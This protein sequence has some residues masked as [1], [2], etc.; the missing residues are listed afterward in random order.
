MALDLTDRYRNEL[1]G[2][3]PI[4]IEQNALQHIPDLYHHIA[5]HST[6]GAPKLVEHFP[7]NV[8]AYSARSSI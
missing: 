8:F 4:L 5:L 7:R 3:S 6:R 2:L 1:L